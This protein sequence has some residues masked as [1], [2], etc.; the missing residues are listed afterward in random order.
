MITKRLTAAPASNFSPLAAFHT[1][2]AAKWKTAVQSF[3]EIARPLSAAILPELFEAQVVRAP[4]A[5]ALVS[6]DQRLSYAELDA[7]ANRLAHLLIGLGVGPESRVSVAFERS[8]EMIVALLAIL[9]AG[10]AYVPLDPQYPI[11]RLQFMLEDSGAKLILS[12]SEIA[13]RLDFGG[14]DAAAMPLL[15]DDPVV[16]AAI[17]A[18]PEKSPVDA[19]RIAHLTPENLAY[20]MYTSGSTGT[21][22]GVMTTQSN[23]A[24]LARLPKYAPL[25]PGQAV[26]QLA[27]TAFDAATFEIWGALLN[28]ARLVLAPPGPPDLDRIA[29]T[30]SQHK[31]DTL[32]LTAGLFRQTIETHPHLLAGVTQLLAGGDILPVGTVRRAKEKHPGLTLIN[33]YGP[34]ET[35]TF[36]CTR[37]ITAEDLNA[38]RIPIGGPIPNSRVYILDSCL[39]PVPVGVVGELYIAGAGLARGYL[40]RPGLSAERFLACPFGAPGERM[41][42]SGDLARLLPDGALDFLGRADDQ[43]KLRG[44]RVEPGE[45]EAALAGIDGVGQAVV[46]LREISGDARLVAYLVVRHGA[47]LPAA[48]ELRAALSARL[49][50][51]MIPAAFVEL[52]ALPLTANGKL[53]RRALPMPDVPM[54][55]RTD[56]G[57]EAPLTRTERRLANIWQDVLGLEEIDKSAD[58]FELGGHSLLAIR[59]IARVEAEFGARV[60]LEALFKYPTIE[61]FALSLED[62]IELESDFTKIVRLYPGNGQ[63]Q[64][65]GINGTGAFHLLAKL[66]GPKLPLTSLQLSSR[67]LRTSSC[68]TP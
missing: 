13:L 9:K 38:E 43:I 44:F 36:A 50:D 55:K 1:S 29:Q 28:G 52:G 15:L 59:V 45:I 16:M 10:G 47:I 34:T 12:T 35:T 21:P 32:W 2:K 42:R 62:D 25:G 30:I 63:P 26:L 61:S 54:P 57:G 37:R 39:D 24:A 58:F 68:R 17:A 49:P 41:Y 67:A 14:E 11:E 51:Y 3:S 66:L 27:P 53:D 7:A 48:G 5:I 4:D 8:I 56:P 18:R 22:K 33:G 31:V 6:D 20:V 40:G 64:I 19:D 46:V 60:A 23:V 65:F